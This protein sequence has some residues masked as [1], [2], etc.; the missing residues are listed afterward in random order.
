MHKI[1]SNV[2]KIFYSQKLRTNLLVFTVIMF[3]F[4]TLPSIFLAVHFN[5]Y[6][7]FEEIKS[8]SNNNL[9]LS[10][11]NIKQTLLST[12][13]ISSSMLSNSYLQ[14]FLNKNSHTSIQIT[15]LENTLY[16]LSSTSPN[17]ISAYLYDINSNCYYTEAGKKKRLIVNEFSDLEIYD[18]LIDAK[19]RIICYNS[20]NIYSNADGISVC[21]IVN[22]LDTLIPKGVLV[23]NIDT[24]TF[25]KSL[26]TTNNSK[27]YLF[28]YDDYNNEIFSELP[29]NISLDDVYNNLNSINNQ[30]YISTTFSYDNQTYMLSSMKLDEYNF[31]VGI[32]RNINDFGQSTVASTT[33]VL[34]II[35]V[36]LLTLIVG[37]YFIS[38]TLTMP[39]IT[40]ANDMSSVQNDGLLEIHTSFT[41]T[42]EIGYL[43]NSYNDM[44]SKIKGL[45]DKELMVEKQKRYLEL[46]LYQAQIK[47]HFLY[48][49][50]DRIRALIICEKTEAANL[51]IKSLGL[52]YQSVLNNGRTI[53][54][55]ENELNSIKQYVAIL[56][57]ENTLFFD[58]NYE[59]EDNILQFE[60]LKFV[61]QPIVENCIVHGLYGCD[62]GLIDIKFLLD[63]DTLSI[64][65]R[66][67][68]VGMSKEL[69]DDILSNE[70]VE[71]NKS[72]GLRSTIER[73]LL[74]YGDDCNVEILSSED[75]GTSIIFKIT[76]YYLH[77]GA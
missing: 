22:D 46:N 27:Q 49:T 31:S 64:D 10:C 15:S 39:I 65:V 43:V 48:N 17:Y 13:K 8:I 28:S 54:T 59:V 32:I 14:S 21:R 25:L 18:D 1:I 2:K 29:N 40:I 77:G 35:V 45:L 24:K 53:V 69:I 19:G 56:K 55:I 44:I 57:C 38:H 34:V 36:N 42:N 58:I 30:N 67:N 3:I 70:K 16:N 76:N 71:N 50:L 11:T 26:S 9:D 6:Y 75:K 52:Y 68:G 4:I 63:N 62:D 74:Y 23:L 66:D 47:P 7:A 20:K 33:L 41:N 37:V 61:L 60:M 51:L 72:F 5:N 12:K 73:M